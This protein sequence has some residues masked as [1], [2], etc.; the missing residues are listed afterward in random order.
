M[1]FISRAWL[2]MIRKKG[3]SILLFFVLLIMATFVLTALALGNAS[4]AAQQNLRKSLGGS[5]NIHFDY[6]DNNPYLK[7][8]ETESGIIA[9][10][11]QQIEPELVEKIRA[12][13]GVKSCSGG[14]RCRL[15]GTGI[16]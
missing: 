1:N 5:F 9:Y 8:E 3:K 16:I 7:V 2:Y 4:D 15:P 13:D 10:C 12:I 11:T 6:S 14:Q